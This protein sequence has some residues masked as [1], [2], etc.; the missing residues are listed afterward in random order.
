MS[1]GPKWNPS[2]LVAEDNPFNSTGR[3][4][5]RE[6]R[7]PRRARPR[8]TR[9]IGHGAFREIRHHL[10][11]HANARDGWPRGHPGDSCF[12]PRAAST[13]RCTHGQRVRRGSRPLP[14]G[15]YGRLSLEAVSRRRLARQVGIFSWNRTTP[16]W[17][18]RSRRLAP[19]SASWIRLSSTMTYAS[20][21]IVAS[22]WGT[23]RAGRSCNRSATGWASAPTLRDPFQSRE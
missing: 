23:A 19:R 20:L 13:H 11:G 3:S 21:W 4:D 1:D 10:H 22:V 2:I 16:S 17:R 18:V 6:A 7:V 12:G 9:S 8:R 15:R 5:D 14:R